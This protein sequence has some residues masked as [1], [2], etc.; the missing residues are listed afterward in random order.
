MSI[1][2]ISTCATVILA[3]VLGLTGCGRDGALSSQ[4]LLAP[5]LTS[6]LG[7]LAEPNA[8]RIAFPFD[9][10][11]FVGAVDNPYFPLTPGTV[12]SYVEE[13]PEGVE[14][15][16]V[17]VTHDTKV[18][19]GVTTTVVW[20]RVYLNGSLK[21]DT[22]DW[23]APDKSGNVWY[24]GEDTKEV[25][26]GVVVST[27]GSWEAGKNGAKAGIIMLANPKIG[28][29]YYQEFAPGVVEDQGRVLSLKES[30]SVPYGAFESCIKTADWTPIEPG[31]RAF[32]YYARGIGM[33]LE[34]IPRDGRARVELTSVSMP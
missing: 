19:L 32:K 12:Y 18:I 20:D 3:V 30:V 34:I 28:D 22:F 13:T 15:N 31:N 23:Y 7:N 9:P 33:V 6:G 21:E 26:N 10:T 11:N 1:K 24:F 4:D 29:T 2:P 16:E 27:A 8:A 14:T 17:A 5:N 25:E